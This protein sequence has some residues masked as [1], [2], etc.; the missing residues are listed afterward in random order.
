MTQL[1]P[2][3][4]RSTGSFFPNE[5]VSNDEMEEILGRIGG[6]PS[7][8]RRRILQSN[9]IQSRHYAIDRETKQMSHSNLDITVA[10]VRDAVTQAGF[11]LEELDCLACG[12]TTPDQLM[13]NHG[14]MVHGE[15][16]C[17][18]CEVVAT[19][20]ACLSGLTALKYAA[21]NVACGHAKRALATGSEVTSAIMRA[22]HFPDGE[23][24]VE[25]LQENP[26][27]AFGQ[28]FLRWMLSDGAGALL[29]GNQPAT[30]GLS[31]RIDWIDIVSFANELE[32]CMYWGGEKQEDGS[33]RGWTQADQVADAIRGGMMNFTQDARLLGREIG[34]AM[35]LK[36]LT[37]VRE[38]H[39]MEA[40]EFDWF[41]PHYSSEYFRQE[42][43][44][45]LVEVEFP[46]PFERWF[47]NLTTRGNTGAASIYLMLDE[48]FRSD[49]L[50]PGQRILGLVPESARFSV[51]Y[52]A[53]T[54]VES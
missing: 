41:L 34:R 7:R 30:S 31:L 11:D 51:G 27:F 32:T 42:V 40:E 4:V 9:G 28:D 3:F 2:V 54:V 23:T 48:L 5:P 43:H 8:A 14:L 18:P 36:G 26:V 10:A 1:E 19:S 24:P 21:M 47:T 12:T 53:L 45:R 50:R 25:K 46:I 16:G 37:A 38:R 39:P 35:I 44:D 52:M 17:R 6:Q 20:G 15:L 33:L 49:K 22:T 13:P 29:L